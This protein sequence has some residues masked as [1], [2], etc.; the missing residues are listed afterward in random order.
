MSRFI[1]TLLWHLALPAVLLRLCWRARKQAEYLQHIAE[2]FGRAPRHRAAPRLWLHAVSVGETRGAQPLIT[3][4]LAHWPDHE[5]LLTHMTPTGRAAGAELFGHEPR[6]VQS[7]LPYD[8]PW[9]LRRFLRRA[10]PA[11]G[12]IMETEVWPNLLAATQAAKLPVL[13]A[14]GRLSERSA[15]GYAKLGSL[16]REAFARFACISAQTEADAA[17]FTSAGAAQVVVSGNIKFDRQENAALTALGQAFKSCAGG[18]PILLMACTR[19]GE[20]EN[21]LAAY[22]QL[23]SEDVLLVL[24]PRHPQRFDKVAQLIAQQNLSMARRSAHSADVA[25][26]PIDAGTQVWLGDSMGE[27]DAYCAMADVAIYGGSWQ[28]LGGH[29]LLEACAAGVPVIV[30]PHTFNFAQASE[31]AIAAGAALRCI[32]AHSAMADALRLLQDDTRRQRMGAAGKA[33]IAEHG[34]AT[35]RTLALVDKLLQKAGAD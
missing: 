22:A 17:R 6:I 5:I 23:A 35:A 11:A 3:A 31:Q 13:L 10:R 7:Y 20:E 2:R 19:E 15:R 16:G 34:G 4:L 33:F 27:M 32:D 18:R 25:L 8:L 1:Y 30:G 9:A 14:N 21:L 28:P 12:I 26:Q 24:V 29:N